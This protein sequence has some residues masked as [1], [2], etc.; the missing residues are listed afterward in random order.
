MDKEEQQQKKAKEEEEVVVVVETPVMIVLPSCN[1]GDFEDFFK[2]LKEKHGDLN[3]L[4]KPFTH[5]TRNLWEYDP[6][7]DWKYSGDSDIKYYRQAEYPGLPTV[8]MVYVFPTSMVKTTRRDHALGTSRNHLHVASAAFGAVPYL[9]D[10]AYSR[11]GLKANHVKTME[12]NYQAIG[13]D[14]NYYLD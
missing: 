14:E 10:L 1:M 8:R 11:A 7:K 6:N 9:F 5:C 12:P 4:D 3:N 2:E 13:S